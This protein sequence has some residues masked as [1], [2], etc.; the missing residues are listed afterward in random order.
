VDLLRFAILGLGAG[1]VYGLTGQGIVL[2]YR[3]SGVVN[4]AQGALGMVGAFIF[5]LWRE[6]GVP[7][8]LAFI[9]AIGFGA[10]VGAG[11]HLLVMRPLR[12]APAIA[13]LIASLGLFMVLLA[14]GEQLWGDKPHLSA[15]L[16]PVDSVE[17]LPDIR[18]GVDRLIILGIAIAVTIGLTVMSRRTRFGLATSAVAEN[19]RATAALGISPDV[20]AAA[21]WALGG[22]LAVGGAILVVNLSGLQVQTLCLLVVPALAAALVG[23]FR[24][25]SLTLAGGLLI[26]ILESEVAYIQTRYSSI[27]VTGWSRSVPFLVIIVVLVVRGRGLPLRGDVTERPPELGSGRVRLRLVVPITLIAAGLT[28]LTS[29]SWAQAIGLTAAVGFVTLSVVIVTGYTGQL[30]LAQFG[31]AGIGAWIAARLVATFDVPFELAMLAG[32]AG[33][34][35]VGILVGLPA[36]RTRG[37][38][39]AVATLGLALLLESQILANPARTGGVLGTEVGSVTFFGIDLD[40]F[41]YPERYAAFSILLVA[42]AAMI[43]ANLRRSRTGRRLIAVR[44]NERAAASLGVSVFGAKLYAF[45]LGA[46]FAA[47]GGIL[48]AF[49]LP[50]V[51]FFP[52]F[53]VFESVFVVVFAVIGGVGSAVGALLGAVLA[54]GAL[55]PKIFELFGSELEDIFHLVG[56]LLLIG[57]LIVDP[58]G[59][60]SLNARH[61][62]DLRARLGRARRQPLPPVVPP[63][64]EHPRVP[65]LAL[66]VRGATVRYGGVTALDDVSLVVQPGEVV[67]LIGAN[68]AGKTTLIDATT[69]FAALIGGGRVALGPD[70]ITSWSPRRRA[71]AGLGRS[72]QSLELFES[73]TVAENLQAACDP[74]DVV[75][76]GADLVR[77]DRAQFT[78]RAIA[79]IHEFALQPDLQ[80]RPDELPYG[81]RRLVAIAR[82]IAAGGSVL[83]LDEPAAGL[84]ANE[85]A[86][87]GSLLRRLASEWGLAILVVEHDV[88][89]VLNVCDRVAV[90]SFGRKIAEGSPAEIAVNSDVIESY[91][92]EALETDDG[93]A[94]PIAARTRDTGRTGERVLDTHDLSAGYGDLPAVRDIMLHVDAGEIVALLGANGAGKTTTLLALAGELPLL[95]GEVVLFGSPTHAPLHQRAREGVGFVPEERAIFSS[96]TARANLRL[97]RGGVA[98]AVEHF[99]ELEPLLSKQAGLLSGG[100]Q[101]ILGLARALAA[102][103]RLLLVDEL[104][105]GLAP[106]VVRRLL[107]AIRRGADEGMAVVLVEQHVRHALAVADRCYVLHRGGIVLHRDASDAIEHL[108]DVESA[109]LRGTVAEM[110][111]DDVQTVAQGGA[112]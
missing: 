54:Q 29:P 14:L 13:R 112:S 44:T 46:A 66:D 56:G 92:G 103:P 30:S 109:F 8:W 4:F 107:D 11:T 34:V 38:N 51:V 60:V 48:I 90:L 41:R 50:T 101:Q 89:L 97:G 35:P 111:I 83:L 65:P 95:E 37:V 102:R 67:G 10:V 31:L 40:S 77:P 16:L 100:E 32:I 69:G 76:Y 74:R 21:N 6:S 81:R 43:T 99:P 19:R 58:N 47:V 15:K 70:D 62:H 52:T 36:L 73:L 78:P 93:H 82:A 55:G 45:G 17:V 53:Q 87:L 94:A 49:R 88:A 75:A 104:S 72:F 20:V 105:L 68:G 2:I 25:F 86:E 22:V 1:A 27:D 5:Y 59:L 85:R 39:L 12:R 26:G 96:L 71:L 61:L 64:T 106:M 63:I 23:S 42:V 24:S 3:G 57:I 9:A 79:A 84:D 28:L 7:T 80:R 98:G 18:V 33:A 91:L 108:A 110:T